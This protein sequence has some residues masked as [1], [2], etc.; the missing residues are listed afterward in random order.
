MQR[1]SGKAK[2]SEHDGNLLSVVTGASENDGRV[3]GKFIEQI[4]EI[5]I[6]VLERKE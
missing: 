4:N 6:L 3:A 1:D 2:R 5:A